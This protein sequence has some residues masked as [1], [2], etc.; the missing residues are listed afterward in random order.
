MDTVRTG[1][2][3]LPDFRALFEA[4]PGLYLVLDSQLTIVAVNDAYARA[5]MTRRE[6]VVG[7][8]LFDVFPD[9]PDDPATEGVRNLK[10]SLSRVFL[11][12]RPDAMAVQKYDIRRPDE[13]GGGFEV[14]YWSPLNTPVLDSEG[15]VAWIIHRVEDVTDFVRLKEAGAESHQL[16]ASLQEKAMRM[17]AEVFVRGREVADASAQLKTANEELARLYEKTRELDELKTRFFANV[18]HE[19]RTPLALIMGPVEKLIKS[20]RLDYD[21]KRELLVAQRNARLL[22]RH[23]ND[24]LDIAKLEAG[25][26]Q[27]R[28]A[29]VDLAVLTRLTASH[30]ETLAD[31]RH[32]RFDV[33]APA[34]MPAQVD[35]EKFERILIN[36]LS[37]AFKFTP[38]DGIIVVRLKARNDRAILT[39]QDNGPG[40]PQAQRELIFERFRQAQDDASR[41]H[42][43]TGLGLAIVREFAAMHGGKADVNTAPGGGALF[44]VELPLKAPPGTIITPPPAPSD[45][46]HEA[47]T[48]HAICSADPAMLALQEFE[49]A[50]PMSSGARSTPHSAAPSV[51]VVEDNPDMNDFLV[52]TLAPHYRVRSARNGQQGLELALEEPPDLILSDIMM[53][54][55]TGDQMVAELRAS[56]ELEEVPIIM[57]S[58]KTDDVLRVGLLRHGVQD[59]L[60]KP[61][62][63]AELLARVG[64]MLADRG[65]SRKK[66]RASDERFRATFEQAAVGIAHLSPEGHWLR[67]NQRLCDI[68]GYTRDELLATSFRELTHPD[69]L[70]ADLHL[71][72][73]VLDG[74]I[75]N[76]HTELRYLKKDGKPLWVSLTVAL[77]RDEHGAPDYFIVVTEDIERRRQAEEQQRLAA[78]VFDSSAEGVMI[79]DAEQRILA[80][81][82]AFSKITGWSAEEV[83]GKTPAVLRSGRHD[84]LFFQ[85]MWA[86]LK[87]ADQWRGEIWNRKKS[88]EIY[89]EFLTISAVRGPDARIENYV[90]VFADM[91]ASKEFQ[92]NL[93]FLAHHDALTRLPN[94]SL[95]RLRLEHS[96]EYAR[97]H[98]QSLAL[99]Y[100]DLDRFKKLNDNL[101]HAAGD[102]LLLAVTDRL[103]PEIGEGNTLARLGS[104]EFVLLAEDIGDP[105]S[106]LATAR[107]LQDT[108]RR[109]FTVDGTDYYV[110]A[111]IGVSMYPQDGSDADLL[112]GRA[113]VAMSRAKELGRNTI[114]FFEPNMN[115]GALDRLRLETDLRGALKQGQFEVWYQP[116]VYLTAGQ[117]RGAEA[118]IRWRHPQRGLV[119]PTEFVPLLEDLGLISEVGL[120]VMAEVFAQIRKWDEAGFVLPRIALNL[121]V[122]Q[123]DRGNLLAEVSALL[124][125]AGIDPYR[126][127]FEITESAVMRDPLR[128]IAILN[129]FR[130]KG[131]HVAI[132][133]FGTG[134]SSLAHLKRLPLTR[135]KIDYSFVRDLPKNANDEAIVRAIISLAHNLGLEVIAEGVETREQADFL[136][137]EGCAEAQGFRYS[138]PVPP[139]QLPR[140]RALS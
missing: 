54:V 100:M 22:L 86:N 105:Q 61:V 79:T 122:Q 91:S 102:V 25:R 114:C 71:I 73:R 97:L 108:F 113:D 4:A 117:L 28:Y 10:A 101:G 55:K 78:R 58:A 23:V 74:E 124:K 48:A 68:L 98:Q 51:L 31:D 132:D 111:S 83:M 45:M 7:K 116:Q 34:T 41:Q 70:D 19:L 29:S 94:R 26:M 139:A 47:A 137:I 118:L 126:V 27:V 33:D 129:D 80:V 49:H 42:G 125:D 66:L 15:N 84:T 3:A 77:V 99:Y 140:Y 43:G 72:K 109:P 135:L 36:L 9:N 104:D 63:V 18:S 92:Q 85:T 60:D 136:K 133:D 121:S 59:Y 123:F 115:Q 1:K 24:L 52:S 112:I 93:E 87:A 75:A 62:S 32:V 81:N 14:R 107:R 69:D 30:F 134:Y 5:T 96:L 50:P 17:E 120:W 67:V 53:P 90:G 21:G 65:R 128:S 13:E 110:S 35:D 138:R 39:V 57:L 56:R 37:N 38:E 127:E 88:G 44:S 8:H 64:G 11:T 103:A 89:P 76:Y 20:R 95:F 12:R 130:A 6:D 119:R 82:E 131:I 16:A 106:A 2:P 46:Q 40:V